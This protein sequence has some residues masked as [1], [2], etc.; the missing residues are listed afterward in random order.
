VGAALRRWAA[1]Y[2]SFVEAL[3][4]RW[5]SFSACAGAAALPGGTE[6]AALFELSEALVG[7]E[8]RLP[9]A[10][11]LPATLPALGAVGAAVRAGRGR[12]ADVLAALRFA[13]RFLEA[14]VELPT[15]AMV[16]GVYGELAALF[17]TFGEFAG[18]AGG[19]ARGGARGREEEPWEE[20]LLLL[21]LLERVGDSECVSFSS[22]GA[23]GDEAGAARA[24]GAAVEGA[25]LRGLA[26][27]VP[28]MTPATLAFPRV[29]AAYLAVAA[30]V[31]S[32]HPAQ[33]ARLDARLFAALVAGLEA[34]LRH[35]DT[36]VVAS[37]LEAARGLASYHVAARV[38]G[39]AYAALDLGPQLAALPR[40]FQGLLRAVLALALAPGLPLAPP[41]VPPA[42]EALLACIAAD[43]AA[44]AEVAGE[45][46]G[47]HGA[48]GGRVV[49]E[50]TALTSGEGG[51]GMGM[52]RRGRLAFVEKFGVFL[53]RLRGATTVL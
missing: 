31:L 7:A 8:A 36:D 9:P 28:L 19:G 27:V 35:T 29:A 18:A 2:G 30:H 47:A 20:L 34:G 10:W 12:G 4:V 22:C 1:F 25:L 50:L 21:A 32:V 43:G 42:A 49:A 17:S 44:F 15:P 6:L 11:H 14:D 37:A 52:D 39:G 45:L 23:G 41:L 13:L 46:V 53:A 51:R 33:A 5:G 40:L 3:R 16:V 38:K 24:V 48:M 26:V